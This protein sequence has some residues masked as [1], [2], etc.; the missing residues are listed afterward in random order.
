MYSHDKIKDVL[1]CYKNRTLYGLSVDNI[2][3]LFSIAR[4]TLYEWIKIY[5]IL[6]TDNHRLSERVADTVRSSRKL[7]NDCET[8]IIGYV[9]KNPTFNMKKLVKKLSNKYNITLSKGYIYEILKKNNLTNKKV[10]K[11]TYPYGKV[12]FK[13]ES[14][15]LKKAI[16]QVDNNYTSIDEAAVYLGTS[17]NYGW[18]NKGS[19][20]FTKSTFNRSSKRSL[21]IA[22]SNEGVVASKMIPGSFNTIKFN[23]FV[24]KDVIPNMKN[25][26]LLMDGCTIHKSKILRDCL[27]EADVKQIFN[28]PYSP[29]YNPIELY[30]NTLKSDVKKNN[31]T[32]E[33]ELNK[34]L[35]KNNKN[36]NKEGF[37]KY[38][39]HTYEILK[40]SSNN[41]KCQ[42]EANNNK[43][44]SEANNNKCQTEA[45]NNKCQSETNNKICR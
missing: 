41:K 6:G 30:L 12:K 3:K 42:L 9:I 8:F 38:Y 23:D 24:I 4:S 14:N 21:C 32:T 37:I 28:V 27:K 29:Q 25:K 45:Y 19:R 18:S 43:C 34:I 33:K 13:K 10:Q 44:Q 1:V 17:P 5:C 20:C 2:L 26:A 7:T 16:D 31:V 22:I 40:S 35:T 15:I 36:S 11:I 39:A